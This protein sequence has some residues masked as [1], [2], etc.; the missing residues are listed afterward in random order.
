M[1]V[2]GQRP[3]SLYSYNN[4]YLKG[5]KPYNLVM[6]KRVV[7]NATNLGN[8]YFENTYNII[9]INKKTNVTWFIK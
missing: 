9:S 7:N 3:F 6:Y 1:I 5:R 4:F 8:I 2:M